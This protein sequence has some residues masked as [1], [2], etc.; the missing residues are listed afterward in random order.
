MK[1]VIKIA[2]VILLAMLLATGC[3]EEKKDNTT[4]PEVITV[5]QEKQGPGD[6]WLSPEKVSVKAGDKFET[7]LYV[8]S[9]DQKLA[10]YGVT[11]MF[12]AN[13]LEVDRG[14]GLDGVVEGAD[15]SVAAVNPN[16]K[17]ELIFS[18]FDAY[19]KGPGPKLEVAK[20]GWKALKAG[21]GLIYLKVMNLIDGSYK[22]IGNP[23]GFPVEY[24]VQ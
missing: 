8:D 6:V 9:G 7:I 11:L 4:T 10:A 13:L 23:I 21:K 3:V 1:M 19:G 17:G 12:D 15:G 24:E 20:I 16:N 14:V 22:N 5:P 2:S 18:G